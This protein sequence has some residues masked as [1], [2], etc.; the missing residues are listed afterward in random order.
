MVIAE[1]RD[2]KRDLFDFLNLTR[3]AKRTCYSRI[4]R[5]NVLFKRD[6]NCL[7]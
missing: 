7:F 6:R 1:N 3:E 4:E 2:Q 5:P